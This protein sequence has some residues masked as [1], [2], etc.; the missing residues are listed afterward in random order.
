MDYCFTSF[1]KNNLLPHLTVRPLI[2][3]DW[4][5]SRMVL[6]PSVRWCYGYLLLEN[7]FDAAKLYATENPANTGVHFTYNQKSN[8]FKKL[9]QLL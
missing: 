6:T 7:H 3:M 8:K 2:Y 9:T 5:K 1:T 4:F